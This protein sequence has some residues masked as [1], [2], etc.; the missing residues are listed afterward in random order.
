MPEDGISRNTVK[1]CLKAADGTEPKYQRKAKPTLLTPYEDR[2]KG[3]LDRDSQQ[4]KQD[5]R[6]G[7]ALF[8]K[9]QQ[10]GFTGSYARVTKYNPALAGCRRISGRPLCRRNSNWENPS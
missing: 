2:L 3:W 5:R 10:E 7:L 6:T 8:S 9:L 4:A 1:K